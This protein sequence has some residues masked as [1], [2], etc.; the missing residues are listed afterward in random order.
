MGYKLAGCTHLGGVEIDPSLEPI[1]KANHHPKYYYLQDIRDFVER[2]D[3]PAELYHLDILD[4]SPPCST[5][6]VS[7]GRE[8]GWN[9]ERVFREGQ[10]AQRLDDLFFV[11]I[12]LVEKLKPKYAIAENVKGMIIGNAKAY[13]K[14]IV[15]ELN[16]IGYEIQVVLLNGAEIG[17]PQR[18][19]RVFFVCRQK[20]LPE[21]DC[22]IEKQK[23]I[24][25]KEI[26]NNDMW[27][28]LG[29]VAYKY[30]EKRIPSDKSIADIAWREERRRYGFNHIFAKSDEVL[31]TIPASTRPLKYDL[32]TRLTD[33]EI[34]LASSFPLDYDFKETN[35]NYIVGMSV[36][37]LM[38]HAVASKVVEAIEKSRK[39]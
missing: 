15:K 33:E 25:Y 21:I 3:L 31:P 11:W 19:E 14:R 22:S 37:P 13:T 5:F 10:K 30:W 26:K 29:E 6:S 17:L 35:P 23:A 4:G 20:G 34:I 9:E 18:R 7:G 16:N 38:M 32:P 36:P 39:E 24:P 1:Y 12:R 8:K 2:D 27:R 28:P